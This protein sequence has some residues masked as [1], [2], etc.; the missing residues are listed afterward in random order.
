MQKLFQILPLT[1]FSHYNLNE[2]FIHEGITDEKVA[3]SFIRIVI[4]IVMAWIGGLKVCQYEQTVS[5]ILYRIAHSSVI[6]YMYE[7]G[8]NLVPN[9][10]G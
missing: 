9:D 6:S 8:P 3:I 1:N 10:K 7:K 5:H 4:F 2:G